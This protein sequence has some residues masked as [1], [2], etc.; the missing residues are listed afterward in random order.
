MLGF[1][2]GSVMLDMLEADKSKVH[3]KKV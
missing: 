2:G 3:E 1:A